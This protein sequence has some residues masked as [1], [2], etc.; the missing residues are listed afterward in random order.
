[1]LSN[2]VKDIKEVVDYMTKFYFNKLFETESIRVGQ[3]E[4][5]MIRL[6]AVTTTREDKGIEPDLNKTIFGVPYGYTD[7][8]RNTVRLQKLKDTVKSHFYPGKY[9]E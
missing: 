1:M 7:I 5:N 8:M 2:P 3:E 6:L 9:S 4:I